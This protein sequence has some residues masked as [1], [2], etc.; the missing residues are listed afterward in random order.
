[1]KLRTTKIFLLK[2]STSI[3]RQISE[4]I[5]DSN[6]TAD[7]CNPPRPDCIPKARFHPNELPPQADKMYRLLANMEIEIKE[8]TNALGDALAG[9][10]PGFLQEKT[11]AKTPFPVWTPT[12][13]KK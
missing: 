7:F 6:F 11:Y 2:E 12:G 4:L 9:N 8:I 13:R 10:R 3:S 5:K 1:M